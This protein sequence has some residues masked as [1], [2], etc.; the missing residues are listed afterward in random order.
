MVRGQLELRGIKDQAILKAFGAVPR[1]EFVLPRFRHLAYDDL[2]VPIGH[3]QTLD[4]PYEDAFMVQAL[5]LSAKDK[6]LEI[7]TGSGYLT[8]IMSKIAKEVYSIEIVPELAREAE[9]N[10]SRLGSDNTHIKAGDGYLGWPEQAPFDAII[11]TASPP[12]IPQPLVQQLADGGRLLLPL[13]GKERFQEL[14]LYTKRS[15]RLEKTRRLA[16]TTFVPMKGK[17]LEGK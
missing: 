8:A 3:G 11:L 16:P 2:E 9:E 12:H 5:A 6:V 14:M 1:E 10:L 13:G 7:G 17:I 4:R 15:G